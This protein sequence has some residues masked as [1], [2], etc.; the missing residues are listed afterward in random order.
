MIID[1]LK[2]NANVSVTIGLEDL[3][4]FLQEVA[5]SSTS[6]EVKEEKYLSADE[7]ATMLHVDKSTLWRWNKVGYLH[8]IKTGGKSLYKLSDINALREG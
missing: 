3:R 6:K 2:S 4:E 8:K 5:I 7:T 1:L